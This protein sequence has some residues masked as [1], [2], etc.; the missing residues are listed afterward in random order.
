M[1]F[2]PVLSEC[3]MNI[4]ISTSCF[5][6]TTTEE[7]LE[8][9]AA[10]GFREI[11]VFANAPSE[12]TIPYAT[13]FKKSASA[14]GL[15][16]IAFHPFSSFAET[17]CLFG[18]Y[19]RRRQDFY[20]IYKGYFAAASAMGADIFNFHGCRSE[21]AMTDEQYCDIYHKLYCI[22][23]EEGIRFS[24]ENV[25]RHYGG[26]VDFVRNIKRLL[27][28]D[29]YFTLDVKQAMRSGE[30]PCDMRDAM[31][32]S[33]I[34]FHASDHQEDGSCA[35]PGKGVCRYED[36]LNKHIRSNAVTKVIEVYSGD[37]TEDLQLREAADFM[38]KL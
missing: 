6:P 7:T 8:R 27:K 9:I 4:G 24:Q 30:D 34:H 22:A 2:G 18:A 15:K 14:L 1:R 11:E 35:L 12:S 10:L 26:K 36:I 31:G 5:Y 25:N 13:Q 20:D 19:E 3:I 28:N 37:Y 32:E 33:L 38:N 17:Y 23:Q 21:W 29:V 16:V